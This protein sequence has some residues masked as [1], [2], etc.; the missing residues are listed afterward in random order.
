M[1]QAAC[2]EQQTSRPGRAEAFIGTILTRQYRLLERALTLSGATAP[3]PAPERG[4]APCKLDP[5]YTPSL[6]RLCQVNATEITV[7][8][9]LELL[10][11]CMIRLCVKFLLSTCPALVSVPYHHLSLYSPRA[12]GSKLVAFVMSPF[13]TRCSIS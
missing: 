12:N 1:A 4:P 6:M 9:N 11:P 7:A 8:Q 2:L 3:I 13:R 5:P 10:V